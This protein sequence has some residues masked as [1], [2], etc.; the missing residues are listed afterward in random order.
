MGRGARV[1]RAVRRARVQPGGPADP[2]AKADAA[3]DGALVV[4]MESAAVA[5][6]ARTRGI[7]F[8][9]LRVVLDLAGQDVGAL[10]DAV[11]PVTGELRPR[12]MLA[13]LGVR[14]WLWPVAARLGRQSRI[15]ERR[16]R[17]VTAALLAAG[18]EG[19][20]GGPAPASA[21]AN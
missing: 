20:V 18:M 15:A 4:E 14:P 3:R 13:A 11:D 16:L 2:R 8:I 6:E 1:P 10:G 9:A 21:A 5:A 19:L 7:P 12:R 17:D